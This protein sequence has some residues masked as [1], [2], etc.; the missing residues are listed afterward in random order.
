M[1]LDGEKVNEAPI[2]AVVKPVAAT[3][4]ALGL[5]GKKYRFDVDADSKDDVRVEVV[6][7]QGKA[8]PVQLE[9]LPEGGVGVSC[10]FKQVSNLDHSLLRQ[11]LKLIDLFHSHLFFF[12]WAPILLTSS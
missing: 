2:L 5:I 6:D 9:D 12:S 1:L 10:R 11:G 3:L 8:L 4:P 7:P